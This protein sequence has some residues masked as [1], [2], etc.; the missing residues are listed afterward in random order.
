MSQKIFEIHTV[1]DLFNINKFI[2]NYR[3]SDYIVKIMNDLDFK[4]KPW[5]PIGSKNYDMFTGELDG[6]GHILKNLKI[7]LPD[8]S[9]LGL[10]FYNTGYIHDI[11][12]DNTC[13][14]TGND[15]IGSICAINEGEI[16]NC[17]SAAIIKG[18]SHVG[19][20]CGTST[21]LNN[22]IATVNKSSFYG[23]I[24]AHN[25]V[26]GICGDFRGKSEHLINTG[27]IS[28]KDYVG[29]ICGDF[30]GDCYDFKNTG[31]VNGKIRVGGVFGSVDSNNPK[32]I[33]NY[34]TVNGSY[35][36]DNFCGI[37]YGESLI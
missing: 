24:D 18:G 26:G 16:S 9:N 25:I 1:K 3:E 5:T 32:Y 4:N 28:G 35:L 6:K 7:T 11:Y 21:N 23:K 37:N 31:S 14:I 29:G 20:I 34:G 8:M 36:Y 15:C 13:Q 33:E 27:I 30:E 2:S 19:G 22:E 17:K 10:I 12:L